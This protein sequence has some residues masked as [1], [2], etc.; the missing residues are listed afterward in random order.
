M[1][2]PSPFNNPTLEGFEILHTSP[3]IVGL[4]QRPH[5]ALVCR[6]SNWSPSMWSENNPTRNRPFILWQKR[7]ARTGEFVVIPGSNSTN[8]EALIIAL[9]TTLGA[10]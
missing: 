6:Y 7:S 3:E 9:L 1:D 8:C 10:K 5:R 2:T 4:F